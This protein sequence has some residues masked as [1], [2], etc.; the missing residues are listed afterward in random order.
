MVHGRNWKHFPYLNLE[1]LCSR[2]KAR[3]SLCPVSKN[4]LL[5]RGFHREKNH[6]PSL[7]MWP[8]GIFPLLYFQF[9]LSSQKTTY[10]L[11]FTPYLATAKQH[12]LLRHLKM[13]WGPGLCHKEAESKMLQLLALMTSVRVSKSPLLWAPYS[14][15]DFHRFCWEPALGLCCVGFRLLPGL[16]HEDFEAI[17][18]GGRDRKVEAVTAHSPNDGR[19]VHVLVGNLSREQLPQNH[20]KWPDEEINQDKSSSYRSC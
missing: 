18:A 8:Q 12:P 20:P 19:R 4:Q 3:I 7:W 2:Q 14:H 13:S 11:L 10:P 15:P 9:L 17:W 6:F 1:N 16:L 5:T